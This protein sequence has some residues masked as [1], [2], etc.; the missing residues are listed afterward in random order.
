MDRIC[1]AQDT[2]QWAQ[3]RTFSLNKRPGNL[4]NWTAVSYYKWRCSKHF[5]TP[6]SLFFTEFSHFVTNSFLYFITYD[7]PVFG[8]EKN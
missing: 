1:L 7:L 4:I 8:K 3:Q 5:A 2:N 6:C